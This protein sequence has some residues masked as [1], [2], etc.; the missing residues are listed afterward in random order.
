MIREMGKI[1]NSVGCL[2]WNGEGAGCSEPTF[3]VRGPL[4]H[5]F[6]KKRFADRQR[7]EARYELGRRPDDPLSYVGES[8]WMYGMPG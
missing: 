1:F 4:S 5:F 8:N 7:L 2:H 3:W 6:S